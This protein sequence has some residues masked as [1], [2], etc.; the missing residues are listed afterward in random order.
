[1]LGWLVVCKGVKQHDGEVT[2]AT[3]T[4]TVVVVAGRELST[5]CVGA[6]V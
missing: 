3:G 1:M 5:Q 6:R 2:S 4:I